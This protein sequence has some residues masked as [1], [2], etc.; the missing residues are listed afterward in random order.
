VDGWGSQGFGR[1]SKEDEAMKVVS[2]LVLMV[3]SLEWRWKI[4]S[5]FR[6]IDTSSLSKAVLS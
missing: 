5:N 1:G 4:I 3:T 6:S 2:I